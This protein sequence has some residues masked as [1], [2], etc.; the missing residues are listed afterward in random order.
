MK[1][2]LSL[3]RLRL[4]KYEAGLAVIVAALGLMCLGAAGD[5]AFR[6]VLAGWRGADLLINLF[7]SNP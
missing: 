4:S 7:F 1:P 5:V 6:L 2:E 3:P